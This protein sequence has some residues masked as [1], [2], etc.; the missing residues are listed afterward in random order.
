M[1]CTYM[2]TVHTVRHTGLIYNIITFRSNISNE[3]RERIKRKTIR[4]RIEKEERRQR[5]D[6]DRME[7]RNKEGNGGLKYVE[8]R[9][10]KGRMASRLV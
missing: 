8:G 10:K 7:E 3:K 6:G 1:Y 9:S 5:S 4:G 2:Y